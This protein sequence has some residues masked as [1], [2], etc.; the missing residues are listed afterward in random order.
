MLISNV[1]TQYVWMDNGLAWDRSDYDGVEDVRLPVD[2]IWTPDVVLYNYADT[3]LEEKR[4]V[5][6]IVNWEGQVRWRPASIYKSTCQIN[7][8]NFPYDY[9][10]RCYKNLKTKLHFYYNKN[11]GVGLL[12]NELGLFKFKLFN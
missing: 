8:E 11:C 7:I 2:M 9:Q 6:A 5:L 3:R 1:E 4:K 12:S 10:V